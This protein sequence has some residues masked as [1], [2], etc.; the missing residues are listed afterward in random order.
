MKKW[1][2][3]PFI[4]L[5]GLLQLTVLDSWRIFQVKP[6]LLLVS[7]VWACFIFNFRQA[8]LLSIF[9]AVL[10]DTFLPWPFG[11]NTILFPL[12]CFL[13]F[14]LRKQLTLDYAPLQIALIFIV[15]LMQ[16]IATGLMLILMGYTIAAGIFLRIVGVG[17]L[18]TTLTGALS[19]WVLMRMNLLRS[20]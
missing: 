6:D 11:I 4:I 3:I 12:W 10:K 15:T 17:S 1:F 19:L 16:N 20:E 7:M 14:K 2:F 13:I 18:Y 8:F 9:C 5:S